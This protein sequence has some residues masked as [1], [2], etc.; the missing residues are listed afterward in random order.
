MCVAILEHALPALSPKSSSRSS[1]FL[2]PPPPKIPLISPTI[3]KIKSMSK[4]FKLI[5]EWLMKMFFNYNNGRQV[6]FVRGKIPNPPEQLETCSIDWFDCTTN[7]KSCFLRVYL[8]SLNLSLP[9]LSLPT[10]F[11]PMPFHLTRALAQP[12]RVR[13]T[14]AR[15]LGWV[16]NIFF[17]VVCAHA[18]GKTIH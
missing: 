10:T 13:F 12:R 2:A 6:L 1:C 5:I 14:R 8:V 16:R 9:N 4:W 17:F 7:T 15:R 18:L 11:R 3:Y